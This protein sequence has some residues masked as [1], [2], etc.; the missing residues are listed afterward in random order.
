MREE[1]NES[2]NHVVW[3]GLLHLTREDGS[4]TLHNH[5]HGTSLDVEPESG[6]AVMAILDAFRQA[7]PIETFL[8]DHPETSPDLLDLVIRSGCVVSVVELPFLAHGFLRPTDRPVGEAWSWS[9]LPGL[10]ETGSWVVLGVPT[11]AQALSQAGARHGPD[12]IR[13]SLDAGVVS[14]EGDLVDYDFKR[15]YRD[16]RL[17]VFDLG[18]VDPEGGRADHV[19]QRLTKVVREL[20]AQRLRPL[21]LG[22]DHSLTHYVLAEAAQHFE[23]FGV[24]HFDAH[25]DLLPSRTLSHA[26]VFRG[27]IACPRVKH[28]MQIGLRAVERVGP[29]AVVDPCPKRRVVTARDVAAGHAQAALASLPRDLPYY[30]TFDVDCLDG[31]VARE[32]GAPSLGGLSVLQASELV[33]FIARSFDLLG[34]D[35]VEVSNASPLPN[36]A[37]M[38]VAGIL[39]RCLLGGCSFE[40]LSA[41]VY[42]LPV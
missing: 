13:A 8:T 26:N 17:R 19:G 23:R 27:A 25:S 5:E 28:L 41:D 36:F 30:L 21:I 31:A 11:D 39:Q 34:A 20:F 14:G 33:D 9:D 6:P 15:V 16:L 42:S 2:A 32:T 7:Q 37:A 1:L 40:A 35:F 29:Y 4:F 22:G 10:T 3:P 38:A 18:D 24:I 12:E